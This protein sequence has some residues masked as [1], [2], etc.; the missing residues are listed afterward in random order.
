LGRAPPPAVPAGGR[1]G[2]RLGGGAPRRDRGAARSRIHVHQRYEPAHRPES[3]SRASRR[4]VSVLEAPVH[5]RHPDALV[6]RE[7]LDRAPLGEGARDQ[8]TAAAVLDEIAAKLVDDERE[9]VARHIV[10]TGTP[11]EIRHPA[12][13]LAHLAAV[14]DRAQER[15]GSHVSHRVIRTSVP[16]PTADVMWNSLASRLAPPRPRPSPLPV[17]YPSW[18]AWAGS[19]MPG[20]LSEN[21]S[22]R[23]RRL[24]SFSVSSRTTPPPP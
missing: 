14:R 10:Q 18:S 24:P 23:P 9:P 13:R 4:G 6:E 15:T 17:V 7:Q 22:R 21:V 2:W 20:P 19:A 1:A 3:R 16:W 12:T 11:G 5:A 8:I